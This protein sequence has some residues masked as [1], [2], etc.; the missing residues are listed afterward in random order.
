MQL[1]AAKNIEYMNI[2]VVDAETNEVL[3][4]LG[5]ESHFAD[6]ALIKYK[7]D[8]SSYI[9]RTVYLRFVDDA[10]GDYGLFF[11]DNI[12]TYNTAVPGDEYYSLISLSR[13]QIV[14]GGFEDGLN[15]WN[16]MWTENGDPFRVSSADG[17]WG[18]TV[19]Y[20]KVG[21]NL[22]TALHHDDNEQALEDGRGVIRSNLFYLDANSIVT[23]KLGCAP[24]SATGIRFIDAQTGK[25][26]ASFHNTEFQKHGNEGR[27]MQYAYQFNNENRVL[28]YVE[29]FDEVVD[30]SWRLVSVDEIVVNT[31]WIDGSFTAVNDIQ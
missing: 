28:C 7:A 10:T 21:N 26:I 17:Y 29:I 2:R 5:R 23:F 3:Q 27:L 30:G 22:L 25:I 9:G 12:R 11:I 6:C 19:A 24:T 1:G 4:V 18:N 31:T 8:L 14:N 13:T 16:W 20:D 15:G